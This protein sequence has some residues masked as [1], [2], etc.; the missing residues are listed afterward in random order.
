M[1]TATTTRAARAPRRWSRAAGAALLAGAGM[2][3]WWPVFGSGLLWLLPVLLLLVLLTARVISTKAGSVALV[4]WVPCSLVLAGVPLAAL[5]P[6]ALGDSFWA[7]LDGLQT[8][9]VLGSSSSAGDPWPLA[10]GLLSCGLIWCVAGVLAAGGRRLGSA[11]AFALLTLPLVGAL[12]LQQSEETAW[13]GAV[14]LAAGALW[15]TYGRLAVALPATA[16]VALIAVFGAQAV[17][18]QDRWLAFGDILPRLAPFTELDTSQTYGPINDRRSGREMLKITS[19]Q[20]ALWR[21]QVLERFDGRGFTVSNRIDT[22]L[23]QPA[24]EMVTSKVEVVGL[25]NKLVVAPGRITAVSHVD[26]DAG[27]AP[28]E[29]QALTQRPPE[30]DTYAV[31]AAVVA[32]QASELEDVAI[33]QGW[34][35]DRYTRFWRVPPAGRIPQPIALMADHFLPGWGQS[36]WGQVFTTARRLS[37]NTP[38]QLE[39]VRNVMR[40]LQDDQRFTYTTDVGSPGPEPLVDFL[41]NTHKG[42]CQQ[43]AGAAALLLRLAGVP[44]RVVTGFATGSASSDGGTYT[45]R[46]TDAHAWI[47]VYFP[48][49]GW[50]PFNP[51]P[52]AAEADVAPSLDL[53][54]APKTAGP[55][56][57]GSAAALIGGLAVVLIGGGMLARRRRTDRPATQLGELLARLVPQPA[58]PAATLT[59]LR[60]QLAGIGPAVAA[61][62]EQ[63][64]HQRFA[65]EDPP[66]ERF[67]RT[68][69]WRAVVQDRGLLGAARLA[70][71]RLRAVDHL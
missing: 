20:P 55:T 21:M 38:S 58:G 37:K 36:D 39:V 2:A 22:D 54:A 11:V 65:V 18:P 59:S 64:E 31:V 17:G 41:V 1:S 9:T 67:P 14:V 5:K 30:G 25:R 44:T 48:G 45:V 47:E 24:A 56:D 40:Y 26:G 3:G 34:Q 68:R 69:V 8:L 71:R 46:D 19:P 70:L 51:T 27:P 50:V 16:V 49:Y 62:T 7:W 63:A 10:A 57:A 35:Y 52:A 4:A 66:R 33:P 12:A 53:F 6:R 42:Y 43:F 13:M 60:P 61:L 32:P 29:G 15:V 28:G 23:P